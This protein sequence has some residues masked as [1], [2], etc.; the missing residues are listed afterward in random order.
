MEE[1]EFEEILSYVQRRMNELG[2]AGLNARIVDDV[3]SNRDAVTPSAQL[4]DYLGRLRVETTLGSDAAVRQVIRAFQAVAQTESGAQIDGVSV[5]VSDADQ[6]IFGLGP[7]VDL[8]N[9]ANLE[10][11]ITELGGLINGLAESREM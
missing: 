5:V 9:R 1:P 3:R 2:F 4:L 11:V 10:E 7:V 6:Q 8:G